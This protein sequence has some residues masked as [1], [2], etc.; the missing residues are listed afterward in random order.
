MPEI[1]RR[2][3]YSLGRA[4]VMTEREHVPDYGPAAS[5]IRNARRRRRLAEKTWCGKSAH[6]TQLGQRG[7]RRNSSFGY[8]L[9]IKQ[10]IYSWCFILTDLCDAAGGWFQ[11]GTNRRIGKAKDR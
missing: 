11:Q 9:F 8:M 1:Q 5:Q 6:T 7:G 3:A 10:N 4:E 2:V